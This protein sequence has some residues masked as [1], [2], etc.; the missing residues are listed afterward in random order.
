MEDS[1]QQHKDQVSTLSPRSFD[2]LVVKMACQTVKSLL[3]AYRLLSADAKAALAGEYSEMHAIV[4]EQPFRRMMQKYSEGVC[5][6]DVES[7]VRASGWGNIDL[8][9]DD[10]GEPKVGE[11]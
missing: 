6:A 1:R 3:P 2:L 11:L 8:P 4:S 10:E 7:L 9:G 5:D